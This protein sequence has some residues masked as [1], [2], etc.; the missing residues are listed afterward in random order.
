MTFRKL[1]STLIV[2]WILLAA[3]KYIFFRYFNLDT[4]VLKIIF[5][6]L[7]FGFSEALTRRLGTLNFLEAMLVSGLY[8][9]VYII[10]DL[11]V[12]SSIFG[13]EIFKSGMYWISYGLMIIS[14]FFFHKKR[15][16]EIRK[17]LHAA[18]HGHH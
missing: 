1:F 10:L 14:I 8:T 11:I 15:H 17:Q 4:L 12:L 9:L 6:I 18:H 3:V 5:G 7:V 2:L 16:I 13:S